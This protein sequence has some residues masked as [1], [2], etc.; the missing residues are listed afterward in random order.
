MRKFF[1]FFF[2][3]CFYALL[4]LRFMVPPVSAVCSPPEQGKCLGGTPVGCSI[5]G[6]GVGNWCCTDPDACTALQNAYTEC[7]PLRG[8]CS[9][10]TSITCQVRGTGGTRCCPN[11]PSC[12]VLSSAGTTPPG[13]PPPAA[14]APAAP[15]AGVDTPTCDDGNGT[16]TALGCIPN[17]P[18]AAIA[19]ILP[20]A[21]G[22]GTGLAFLLFLYGAFTLITAG[23]D[24]QKVDSGKSVITSAAS[25]L[26]FIIL[27]ILLLR[28]IGIDILKL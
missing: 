17:Q 1:F 15:A 4:L 24:P 19:K 11:Q 6:F 18:A 10:A 14:P 22:L 16:P 13:D 25:G 3:L 2:A 27:S 9:G 7:T 8:I 23:S 26:I 21:I 5:A 20:W 12:D 28:V